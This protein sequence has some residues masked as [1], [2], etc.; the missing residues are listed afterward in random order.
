MSAGAAAHGALPARGAAATLIQRIGPPLGSSSGR[1][2]GGRGRPRYRPTTRSPCGTGSRRARLLPCP[3]YCRVL[4]PFLFTVPAQIR[5]P[6]SRSRARPNRKACST[7]SA[8]EPVTKRKRARQQVAA[9]PEAPPPVPAPR[10]QQ[11][12]PV[13]GHGVQRQVRAVPEQQRRPV[14]PAPGQGQRQGGRS[15]PKTAR[16]GSE[17]SGPRWPQAP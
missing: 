6:S 16:P 5:F 7:S 3:V 12:D 2:P 13:A 8:A 9:P 17:W 14:L 15:V 4:L 10:G 1:A 11:R